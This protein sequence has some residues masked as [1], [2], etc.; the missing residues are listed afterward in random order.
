YGYVLVAVGDNE[1]E[2][3]HYCDWS[4]IPDEMREAVTWPVVPV[5]MMEKSLENLDEIMRD[6]RGNS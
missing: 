2:V 6:Q 5:H 1:T 3:T 4:G